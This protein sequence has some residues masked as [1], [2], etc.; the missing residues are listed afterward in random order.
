MATL[1]TDLRRSVR[2]HLE[3]RGISSRRF[4]EEALGDAGFVA[5]LTRGRSLRLD[6]AD[7]VRVFMGKSPI[8]PAFRREV[9]AF[10][11]TTRTKVS[12]LGVGAMGDPSFVT[13][14]RRGASPTLATADRVRAWM[15]AHTRPA[16]AEAIHAAATDGAASSS[17]I[18]RSGETSMDDPA[19]RY[20]ST[21]E[22]AAFLGLSPRTLDR[23]RVSGAGPAFHKFGNRVRYMQFDLEAWAAGQ[24]RSSTSDEPVALR[25]A[26]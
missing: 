8:G 4:G 22:A 10:L 13:R 14:L 12:A 2:D 11:G 15:T 17:P 26:A 24:R 6:T 25:G 1:D 16:E 21:R 3:R 19:S 20:L 7:R 23:Y 9:E 18:N 5:S